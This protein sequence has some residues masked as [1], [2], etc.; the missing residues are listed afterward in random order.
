MKTI[1][2][3]DGDIHI[4]DMLQDLLQREGYQV[5]AHIQGVPVI[6]LSAKGDTQDK[7]S[8]LLS[9]AADYLTNPFDTKELLTN[10]NQVISKGVMLDRIILD[11]PDCTEGSLKQH[12]SNLRKKL[13]RSG[14]GH[15][16]ASHGSHG[17][18]DPIRLP[19]GQ[20]LHPSLL[21]HLT[22]KDRL[23]FDKRSFPIRKN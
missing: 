13:H 22:K 6:V 7:V 16:P 23:P 2:I 17:R 20:A 1:A 8:L 4:G 12:V 14:T 19:G 18:A 9:G 21:S 10:P 15:R 5:L 11:T 3:I